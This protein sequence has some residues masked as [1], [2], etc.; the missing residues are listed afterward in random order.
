MTHYPS[1]KVLEN[2]GNR[3]QQPLQG[4]RL[5]EGGDLW[6]KLGPE[7][8]GQVLQMQNGESWEAAAKLR[9]HLVACEAGHPDVGDDQI[10]T[11]WRHTGDRFPAIIHGHHLI[12][13]FNQGA[14]QHT[15]DALIV[16]HY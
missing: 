4:E 15:A 9:C 3:C 5:G 12:A 10:E 16:A 8:V 11:L 13:I 14:V 2:V 6:G 1:W 7:R